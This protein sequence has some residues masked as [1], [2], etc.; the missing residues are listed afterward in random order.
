MLKKLPD[1]T[2]ASLFYGIALLLALA[3][4]LMPGA[5]TMPGA[6]I[7]VYMFTPL[8][9]VV[10]M[11]FVITRDGYTK[12]G[13]KSLGLHR[14]GVRAWPAALLVPLLVMGF[15]Y[16]VV[17]STGVAS[18][19]VPEKT[20]GMDLPLWAVPLFAVFLIIQA[21]LTNSLGEEIGWRGYLL[22]R[23]ESLGMWRASL[24]SGFL[25]GLWHLPMILL[26]TLYHPDGN[27]LI[28][29]PLFLLG[30][31][32][33]GVFFGYLRFRTGSVWP[34]AIGH[35]AQNVFW[36]V[37]GAFTVAA[38]PLSTEYLAGETG[39]LPLVGYAV[40]GG[41]LMYT[42]TRSSSKENPQPAENVRESDRQPA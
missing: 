42:L 8:V 16:G 37:F 11:L 35:S 41:L 13:L 30:A 4:A 34:A 6:T 31:T 14:M 29:I 32:I 12:A 19:A 10:I 23:L 38:S 21:S 24:L 15:A 26:T 17:W 22:P 18:F 2:K 3:V 9:A 5:T 25:W 7:I 36:A 20:F 39:I 40:L 27:R 1:I 33:L 28:V